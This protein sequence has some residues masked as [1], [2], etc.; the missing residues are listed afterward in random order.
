M[1]WNAQRIF[2]PISQ[3]VEVCVN[4][5]CRKRRSRRRRALECAGMIRNAPELG[6]TWAQLPLLWHR[7]LGGPASEYGFHVFYGGPAAATKNF[8]ARCEEVTKEESTLPRRA[9]RNPARKRSGPLA[10][11]P[12]TPAP[13]GEVDHLSC[14]TPRTSTTANDAEEKCSVPPPAGTP[15]APQA[16]AVSPTEA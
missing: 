2:S 6:T 9:R 11:R 14:D 16:R 4:T 7:L 3:H 5:C 10:G 15:P 1:C 12:S 8:F 13:R